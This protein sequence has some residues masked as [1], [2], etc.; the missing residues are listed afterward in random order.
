MHLNITAASTAL[1]A[2]WV[3]V[4]NFGLLL[5]AGDGVSASLGQ[6][7]RKVRHVFVTHA[8]RDHVCG[9][10]QLHQLNAREGIPSIH[11][12]KDCGSFPALKEFMEKFDPQSGPATWTGLAPGETVLLDKTHFIEVRSS[13]HITT[14]N[15]IKALNY[16]VCEVRR[17]LKPE[18]RGMNAADIGQL[19]KQQG[20]DAVT[21]IQVE[22]LLCYSGDAPNL[23]PEQWAGVKVLIHEATFLEPETAR[24]SH[25]NVPEVIAAASQLKLEALV[26]IHFSARYEADEIKRTIRE[27]ATKAEL[28]FPV[29]AVM[30]GQVCTDLLAAEPVWKPEV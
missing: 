16:T 9:L 4:E 19:R 1:F 7:G 23:N 30:P 10:L 28:R 5:D 12:P 18:L 21:E 3:F 8:D 2:T 20:E 6:K 14:E 11:Y 13:E 17:N 29:F 25:S 26:L 27:H 24:R 22:R 15:L